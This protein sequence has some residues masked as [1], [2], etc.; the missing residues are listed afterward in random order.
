[1]GSA[2]VGL[3]AA[4]GSLALATI[5]AFGPGGTTLTGVDSL[6]VSVAVLMVIMFGVAMFVRRLG[7]R[8]S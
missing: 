2:D 3:G 5:A 4:T 7:R 1:M 8:G 6:S